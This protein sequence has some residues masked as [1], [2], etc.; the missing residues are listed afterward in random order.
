VYVYTSTKCVDSAK[1]RLT[2][3]DNV[4][5]SP[6]LRPLLTDFGLSRQEIASVSGNPHTRTLNGAAGS[7]PWMAAEF[8]DLDEP[9]IKANSETDVWAFGMTVY[10]RKPS[11]T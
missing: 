9:V 2:V 4:L 10:V 5:L 7:L 6:T 3:K 8:F 1:L 11:L